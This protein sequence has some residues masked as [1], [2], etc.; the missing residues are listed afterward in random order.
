M[1]FFFNLCMTSMLIFSFSIF[2]KKKWINFLCLMT[3]TLKQ[4]WFTFQFQVLSCKSCKWNWKKEISPFCWYFGLYCVSQIWPTQAS[5]RCHFLY[6]YMGSS[7]FCFLT[8]SECSLCC[9]MKQ[10]SNTCKDLNDSTFFEH[11]SSIV[12]HEDLVKLS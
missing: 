10:G 12:L 2:Y 7:Y 4:V 3:E 6:H 8:S 9:R 11:H 1:I 5:I